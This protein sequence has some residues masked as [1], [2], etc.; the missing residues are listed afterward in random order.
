[1]IM[2]RMNLKDKVS[3][4]AVMTNGNYDDCD[5]YDF[6]ILAIMMMTGIMM[7]IMMNEHS[8]ISDKVCC[9]Q[10]TDLSFCSFRYFCSSSFFTT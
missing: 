6:M 2:N 4:H 7:I 8:C 10:H 5:Y 1:M 9:A 3:P